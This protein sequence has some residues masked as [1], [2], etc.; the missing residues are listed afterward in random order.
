[1][2]T[3]ALVA[4][5]ALLSALFSTPYHA[6]RQ[7]T[8]GNAADH[9]GADYFPNVELTTQDGRTVRFFDDL[10]KDK[11]V[12]INFIYTS[13]PD[14]CP[15]ETARLAEVQDILGERVGRDVFLYS[16]T[17]DPA[18]DTPEVLSAYAERFQ[19]KPGWLFL[20]GKADDIALL[21]RKLGLLGADDTELKNHS[22]SLVLG[23]QATGRWMRRS[24]FE[25][26]YVLAN[27]L[28]DW[29]HDWKD[30]RPEGQ[31]YA[32]APELRRVSRG[33]SLFR[34]R[35][36]ACHALGAGDGLARVGPSLD[37][38]LERRGRDW[39]ARWITAPDEMLAQSDPAASA[40]FAAYHQVTMPNLRLNELEVSA[41]IEFIGEA[42]TPASTED[43][44]APPACCLKSDALVFGAGADAAADFGFVAELEPAPAE[45]P[46]DVTEGELIPI[47][48]S[49]GLALVLG[50]AALGRRRPRSVREAH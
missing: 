2:R 50:A 16:I 30:A 39:L 19:T 14:S 28:G 12:L 3:L 23:N 49:A 27:Q 15:L 20:T 45:A 42:S 34:T 25:N 32:N 38:A 4:L 47:R 40:M 7:E 43:V 33:E 48:L 5:S 6:A 22:L 36:S 24:P 17:I 8:S 18:H 41:L 46:R 1:M 26:A 44:L 11:A 31:D 10:V 29:L 35:C 9:W 37:G 13:C 21:R